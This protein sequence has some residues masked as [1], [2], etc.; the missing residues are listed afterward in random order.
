MGCLGVGGV[1]GFWGEVLGW[2]GVEKNKRGMARWGASK[3]HV[4]WR[5]TLTKTFALEG[6]THRD[7][8]ANSSGRRC[9]YPLMRCSLFSSVMRTCPTSTSQ[10]L[11]TNKCLCGVHHGCGV[12]VEMITRMIAN[13]MQRTCK[14][15]HTRPPNSNCFHDTACARDLQNPGCVT[16]A[17]CTVVSSQR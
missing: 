11:G 1:E 10:K 5:V 9:T 2:V 15:G 17:V 13:V 7:K 6:H 3:K 12:C 8:T 14:K 4:R 16:T